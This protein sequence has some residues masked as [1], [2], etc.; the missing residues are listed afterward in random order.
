MKLPSDNEDEFVAL[1][2]LAT[3][4]DFQDNAPR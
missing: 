2:S 1:Y 4:A 3:Q